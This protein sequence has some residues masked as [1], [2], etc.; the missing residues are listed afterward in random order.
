MA[1]I[2]ATHDGCGDV[3]MTSEDVTVSVNV[4]SGHGMYSFLC[5]T[6]STPITKD[7]EPRDI[8]LLV[9]SGV[10][11]TY[12]EHPF[13]DIIEAAFREGEPVNER[14]IED[15]CAFL[16]G[17][18]DTLVGHNSFQDAL[19]AYHIERSQRTDDGFSDIK[20]V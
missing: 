5:P 6:C 8:E 13:E 15:F 4:D 7:A 11:R 12:W 18:P 9:A 10:K 17:Y 14:N 1:I 2:R 3:E 19:D 20:N 16:E